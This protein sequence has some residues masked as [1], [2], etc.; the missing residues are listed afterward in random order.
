MFRFTYMLIIIAAGVLFSGRLHAAPYEIKPADLENG[1]ISLSALLE[2][3]EAGEEVILKVGLYAGPVFLSKPMKLIGE[4][5]AVIDAQGQG[6]VIHVKAPDVTIQGLILQNSGISHEDKDSGVFLD[7]DAHR[8]TVKQNTLLNNLVGVY[9]WGPHDTNVRENKITGRDDLRVNERGNG[10]YIWN[11]PGAYVGFN[12]IEKG[13]DGIFVNTSKENIFEGNRMRNLR[14][15]I[16]YMHT[17][18]STVKNNISEG[19]DAGYALMYSRR[20]KVQGN[21]SLGDRDHGILLNYANGADITDNK[22]I[23]HGNKKCIFIYNS[24]KNT[25][26]KNW[27]ED[28]LIGV[29]FTGGSERN[30]MVN[31]S[32]IN[33]QSQVKYVG[34]RWV[35]WNNDKR[36]N[37]WSDNAPFDMNGDAIADDAFKPNDLVDQIV[38]RHPSARILLSSPAVRILKWAQGQFPGL[39]PGG[40][41]DRYPLMSP[42]SPDIGRYWSAKDD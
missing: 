22:V 5:G 1:G 15:G 26:L 3:F 30:K 14:Y 41:I 23:G 17:N 36:G 25:F 31:N 37:Y 21:V 7:R 2:T 39:Y 24:N 4:A 19:N 27:F 32:F 29:H 18:S 28:C 38:W 42:Q 35:E 12:D 8:A 11:A 9:I 20:L 40:V 10:V 16:H 33:N 6:S 13:R 34:T